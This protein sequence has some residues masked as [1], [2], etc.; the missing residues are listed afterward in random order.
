MHN[1]LESLQIWDAA[2]KA[3]EAYTA[4]YCTYAPDEEITV[5]ALTTHARSVGL[6]QSAIDSM[7]HILATKGQVGYTDDSKKAFRNL[8]LREDVVFR[9][10]TTDQMELELDPPSDSPEE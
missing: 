9:S 3:A 6:P 10:A 5:E 8:G 2:F 1:E 4:I 7:L